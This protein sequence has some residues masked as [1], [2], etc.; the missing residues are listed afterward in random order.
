ML[1]TVPRGGSLSIIDREKTDYEVIKTDDEVII[2]FRVS[3]DEVTICDNEVIIDDHHSQQG[4]DHDITSGVLSL[5][6]SNWERRKFETDD[7]IIQVTY[8]DK[9]RLLS[10]VVF[11][12]NTT[13]N[14]RPILKTEKR[15]R[16]AIQLS[17][18]KVY[19]T[20]LES[21]P[22]Y[23]CINIPRVKNN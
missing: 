8:N 22:L 7:G 15:L 17:S 12:T 14:C 3:D 20:A 2:Y 1:D 23:H 9:I 13:Y 19:Y 11:V 21:Y 18:E 4:N 10:V 16:S 6:S 5:G